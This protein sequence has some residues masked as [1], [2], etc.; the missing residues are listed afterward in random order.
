MPTP[1]VIPR[2][3]NNDDVVKLSRLPLEPGAAFKKSDLLA[4]IET[5]KASFEIEAA[6]D[7]FVLRIDGAIGQMC[8]VGS[9]L[10]WVGTSKDEAIPAVSSA[11]VSAAGSISSDRSP[12]MKALLLLQR[13]GLDAT[14]IPATG[15]RLSAADVEAYARAK[16][17][18][19]AKAT[20]AAPSRSETPPSEV[21]RSQS[22]SPHERGMLRTVTWHRD[23]A[24]AGYIELPYDPH[25]WDRFSARFQE[26]HGLLM[27][28]LLALMAWQMSRLAVTYPKL[29]ATVSGDELYFYD[30][31]NVGFTVQS[32]ELL[33]MP[34]VRAAQSMDAPA[35]VE[36][37]I[38]LQRQA[39]KLALKPE[40]ASGATVAF[41]SMSRW[42]VSRHVPILPPQTSWMIA[43]SAPVQNQAILGAC[44][45]H[46]VLTGFDVVRALREL[47]KPPVL[48]TPIP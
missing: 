35:F 47:A 12:S 15:E 40:Q 14:A 45:D 2:I 11:V 17:W 25:E 44:Y 41:T 9:T 36:A 3:N 31:V 38:G 26:R 48:E 42:G 1:I 18:T 33:L 39:M 30:N 46:R 34:V 21:G 16:G 23:Q 28:P 27:S 43:H 7:G 22:M 8:E 37:L 13:Y 32:G 19:A 5:D 29:N 24:V 10:M 6:T 20:Y 4:E